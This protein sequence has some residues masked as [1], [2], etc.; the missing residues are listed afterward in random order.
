M[1]DL[2][3]S[4]LVDDRPEDGVFRVHK[5]AFRS[6]EVFDL[7]MRRIFEGT[8]VFV[9]MASEARKPHDFFTTNIGRHPILVSRDADGRLGAFINSCRHRGARICQLSRGNKRRHTCGYHG[10]TYDSAGKLWNVKDKDLGAYTAAFDKEDHNLAPL[11]RF[12]EY[13]GFLFAS[14]ST[15]VP[16]LAEHL[17]DARVLLD[18]LCDQSPVGEV[19]LVAGRALYTYE[20]NWKWQLEN[21]T[22]GYHFLNTHMSFIKIL[23]RRAALANHGVSKTI[24]G[25]DTPVWDSQETVGTFSLPHGI[26]VAWTPTKAQPTVPLYADRERTEARVGPTRLQWMFDSRNVTFFP[27]MQ[28]ASNFSTQLRV[29]RPIAPNRTAMDT[30]CLAPVGESAASRELRLRQFEDFFNATGIATPDDNAI[31][32]ECQAGSRSDIA[33]WHQGYMRGMAVQRQGANRVA[34]ELGIHPLNFTASTFLLQ[35][36]TVFHGLYREWVRLMTKEPSRAVMEPGR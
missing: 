20:G 35:D 14:L 32:E 26:A 10:W 36:E 12:D 13:R 19:E 1:G 21:C 16:S 3:P 5:D 27:N 24:F 2:D 15:D 23:G 17:G 11:P 30:F 28:I 18:L 4:S 22:D 25:D 6:Q 29:M 31:Y 9:G 33:N 8:W 34:K 7:E